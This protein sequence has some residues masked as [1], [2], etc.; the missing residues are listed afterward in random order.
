M[1]G[2]RTISIVAM[3]M[4]SVQMIDTF[5]SFSPKA[6]RALKNFFNTLPSIIQFQW[7]EWNEKV[8]IL[9]IFKLKN[10]H[11]IGKENGKYWIW[12]PVECFSIFSI[13]INKLN[14][15]SINK[16][17]FIDISE[18]GTRGEKKLVLVR[19]YLHPSQKCYSIWKMKEENKTAITFTEKTEIFVSLAGKRKL[20][21]WVEMVI[22][23]KKKKKKFVLRFFFKKKFMIISIFSFRSA[24]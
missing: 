6:R 9:R 4:R 14:I 18:I 22:P 7:N 1:V 13:C 21:E 15:Q 16:N 3:D 11:Q 24:V 23:F 8:D 10:H 20:L 2:G 19:I 12:S 5:N 17:E